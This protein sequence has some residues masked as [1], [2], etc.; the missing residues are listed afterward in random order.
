MGKGNFT[1]ENS[2]E[3]IICNSQIF[4]LNI[5]KISFFPLATYMSGVDNTRKYLE[6]TLF[7]ENIENIT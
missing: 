4:G 6:K 2:I 3:N 7:K 5:L 1:L